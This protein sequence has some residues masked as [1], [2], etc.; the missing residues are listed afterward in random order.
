MA[1][2]Q[3]LAIT[4]TVAAEAGNANGLKELTGLDMSIFEGANSNWDYAKLYV[5]KGDEISAMIADMNTKVPPLID[6]IK[7]I[8]SN[9]D[10][11]FNHFV[12]AGY[13]T[14]SQKTTL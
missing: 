8:T 1:H 13:L 7:K 9:G 14:A 12:E 5:A 4:Y 10:V 6:A 11:I 3:Q 2:L